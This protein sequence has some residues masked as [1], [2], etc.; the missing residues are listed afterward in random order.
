MIKNP[1]EAVKEAEIV[2]LATPFADAVTAL[3]GFD[4]TGKILL[5]C[6]NPVG[7]GLTHGLDSKTS[8]LFFFQSCTYFK[9]VL[10]CKI[11]MI[12]F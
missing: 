5:D 4:L 12:I 9:Y 11:C 2:V 1:I 3:K 7:A 8:G 10:V 6:T